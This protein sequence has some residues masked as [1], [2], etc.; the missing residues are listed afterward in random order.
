MHL[1]W[2]ALGQVAAVSTGVTVAVVVVF[3][4]GV[5]GLAQLEGA[6]DQQGRTS[7]LGLTQAALCFLACAAVVAYGIFLI[8]PQFH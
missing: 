7:N 1:D 3:A 2:T 4:L 8:V 5:L 6:R